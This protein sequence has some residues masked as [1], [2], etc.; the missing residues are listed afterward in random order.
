[1]WPR[2]LAVIPHMYIQIIS[3]FVIHVVYLGIGTVQFSATYL[4]LFAF[5]LHQI[6]LL[7][8]LGEA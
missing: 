2:G 8:A 4:S 1:M 7:I 3:M 6:S 5:E